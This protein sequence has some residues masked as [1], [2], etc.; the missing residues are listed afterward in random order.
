MFTLPHNKA[1]IN[2]YSN[3]RQKK[4]MYTVI[5]SENASALYLKDSKPMS[6]PRYCDIGMIACRTGVVVL[7][8]Q[9]RKRV[10]D[11]SESRAKRE[12]R[13]R[14]LSGMHGSYQGLYRCLTPLSSTICFFLP[15]KLLTETFHP[16]LLACDSKGFLLHCG[17]FLSLRNW[18]SIF[19]IYYQHVNSLTLNRCFIK[20]LLQPVNNFLNELFN[21]QNFRN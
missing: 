14:K 13:A 11:E 5:L 16:W 12:S 1:V 20:P 8:E 3:F 4:E 17:L 2:S 7:G 18:Y 19:C 9:R 6:I 10:E 15:Q 21:V